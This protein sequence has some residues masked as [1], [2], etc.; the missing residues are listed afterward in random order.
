MKKEFAVRENSFD[1]LKLWSAFA[2]MMLHYT[3]YAFVEATQA[4]DV[5]DKLR[6]TAQFFPGVVVFI[7]ISGFLISDSLERS[8]SKKEFLQKRVLRLYPQLWLCTIV[9]LIFLMIAAREYL[10]KGIITWVLTQV[11]GIANTPSC[12]DGFATGSVNGALWTIFVE[13]QLYIIL[14]LCYPILKRMKVYG[15]GLLLSGLAVVNVV[16]GLVNEKMPGGM[17]SKLIER[18]FLPYAIWFFIGVFCYRYKEDVMIWLKRFLIPLFAGYLFL[19]TSDILS[20][21]YYAKIGES[22]LCPLLMIGLAYTLPVWRMKTELSYGMF[23]YHWIVLNGIVHYGL[24]EIWPWQITLLF[25][26]AATLA[27]AWISQMVSQAIVEKVK[28]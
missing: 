25:F 7:A 18:S 10:D 6:V 24:M 3:Y 17:I 8:V 9:N 16:C 26:I 2:V 4:W 11:V 27:L 22:I 20:F 5:M 13:I 21:G 12:L 15:W 23:L 28:R 14:C 19:H 1:I